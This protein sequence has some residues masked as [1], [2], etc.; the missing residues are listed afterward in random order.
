MEYVLGVVAGGVVALAFY[1][2]RMASRGGDAVIASNAATLKHVDRATQ[3]QGR[4]DD[5]SRA[6]EDRDR[7]I[8]DHQDAI[9]RL[10]AD[11]ELER[12]GVREVRAQRDRA[13]ALVDDILAKAG[14]GGGAAAA[15]VL[16]DRARRELERLRDLAKEP[17]AVPGVRA[18]EAGAAGAPARD[19]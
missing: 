9:A 19:R 4:V 10:T 14:V 7:A 12:A 18:P 3:L 16:A 13:L 2:A 6:V 11:L 17:A 5:L 1:L 8:R 15:A